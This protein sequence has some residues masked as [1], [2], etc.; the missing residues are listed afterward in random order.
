MLKNEGRASLCAVQYKWHLGSVL[1]FCAYY[2][3]NG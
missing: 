3:R 1:M 2:F